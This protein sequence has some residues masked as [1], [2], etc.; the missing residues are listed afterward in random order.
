MTKLMNNKNDKIKN[1]QIIGTIND[2][3]LYMYINIYI[4]LITLIN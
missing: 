2:K 4:Y 1:K 3:F